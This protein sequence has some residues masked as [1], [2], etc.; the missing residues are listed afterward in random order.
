MARPHHTSETSH[1]AITETYTD[2]SPKKSPSTGPASRLNTADYESHTAKTNGS[3]K[4]Q[5]EN[6]STPDNSQEDE[7]EDETDGK[8]HG[9]APP[10]AQDYTKVD[11]RGD[12]RMADTEQGVGPPE[13]E[14]AHDNNAASRELPSQDVFKGRSRA[15]SI[16]SASSGAAALDFDVP[17][18]DDDYAAL[19]NV[20]NAS[21]DL[22]LEKEESIFIRDALE[23][24]NAWDAELSNYEAAIDWNDETTYQETPSGLY[25]DI[26][27]SHGMH[28]S[29]LSHISASAPAVIDSQRFL[30]AFGES[31]IDPHLSHSLFRSISL[32]S[33]SS[34]S[35][36]TEGIALTPD[37]TL[38]DSTD[39]LPGNSNDS[40]SKWNLLR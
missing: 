38:E 15:S 28:D 7:A 10:N 8:P 36:T 20:S 16:S 6:S 9:L 1:H 26:M 23:T 12:A 27:E 39:V 25:D 30:P 4:C 33:D 31:R 34:S 21:D 37:E 2:N 35:S 3:P 22:Q 24:D 13:N 40:D 17:D 19:D 29:P 14:S 32:T 5:S 18:D 11:A